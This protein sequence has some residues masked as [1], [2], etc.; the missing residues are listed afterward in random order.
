M[1]LPILACNPQ[2]NKAH[3]DANVFYFEYFEQSWFTAITIATG[4][5]LNGRGIWDPFQATARILLFSTKSLGLLAR[6]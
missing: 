5:G 6:M 4:Y 2:I 1:Q 3:C